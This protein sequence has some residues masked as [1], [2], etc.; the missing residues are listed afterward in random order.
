M[1]PVQNYVEKYMS[2]YEK[3]DDEEFLV[4]FYAMERWV[5][6]NIPV[7]G[8]TFREFVKAF[9]RQNLLVKGEMSLDGKPVKLAAITCPLL[10]LVARHDH[11]VPPGST[12]ALEELVGS[13]EVSSMSIDAGHIGLA[14]GTKAHQ[15]L[16]PDATNWIADHS[17]TR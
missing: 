6:D 10:M 7:A 2:Y 4:N 5:N 9:Y 1:K 15:Q 12:L 16:W 11:L 13:R 14:V 17:T 3:I 8:E